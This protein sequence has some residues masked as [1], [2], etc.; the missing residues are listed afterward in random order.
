MQ[1][2]QQGPIDYRNFQ[3]EE[4]QASNANKPALPGKKAGFVEKIKLG[5]QAADK[6]T[7]IELLIMV[8]CLAST[9]TF[10]SLFLLDRRSPSVQPNV[11]QNP[12]DFIPA[13]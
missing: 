10:L 1:N 12:E 11:N 8:V 5:W 6:K 4:A 9:I 13:E 2:N 3:K 7:K